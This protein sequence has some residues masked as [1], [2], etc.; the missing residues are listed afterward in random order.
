MLAT[1]VDLSLSPEQ[2][3]APLSYMGSVS[4]ILLVVFYVSVLLA[5]IFQTKI[6]IVL[7]G[8]CRKCRGD[9]KKRSGRVGAGGGDGGGGQA[10]LVDEEE[11]ASELSIDRDCALE[12]CENC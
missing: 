3:D 11:S 12:G 6:E 10:E 2:P 8:W 4:N 9:E 5:Y 1:T 7:D